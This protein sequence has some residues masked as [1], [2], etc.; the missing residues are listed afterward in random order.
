VAGK[1]AALARPAEQLPAELE[2]WAALLGVAPD[3]DRLKTA[4]S[5]LALVRALGGGSP[6]D[7]L[8][9]YAPE[10][11]AHAVARSLT[12]AEA[13][14]ALL[15]ERLVFGQLEAVAARR[16]VEGAIELIERAAAVVRQD[17]AIQELAPAIR[18][19]AEDAQRLLAPRP[20]P[21]GQVILR[22]RASAKG[23]AAARAELARLV[24]DVER[25]IEEAG[26]GAELRGE[27]VVLAPPKDRT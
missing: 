24:A 13:T 22:R 15:R 8:A 3:A 23:A 25:A 18:K 10:T 6:V 20:E 19:L 11:S 9:G 4:R 21:P 5:A 1:V 14:V 7:V 27:L 2:R 17:E 26:D 12:N 16:D